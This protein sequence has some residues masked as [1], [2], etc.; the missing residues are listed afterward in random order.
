[1]EK[2]HSKSNGAKAKFTEEAE[3]KFAKVIMDADDNRSDTFYVAVAVLVASCAWIVKPTEAKT[4]LQIIYLGQF[5]SISY[6]QAWS[7]LSKIVG[8]TVS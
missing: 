5:D 1:M 3:A 2:K 8:I 7:F 4:V 6:F